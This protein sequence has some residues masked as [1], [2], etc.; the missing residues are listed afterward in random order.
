M[1]ISGKNFQL[2]NLF[3]N[4]YTQV[5]REVAFVGETNSAEGEGPGPKD[6]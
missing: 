6:L 2:Y 3:Q 5:D 4:P 1:E